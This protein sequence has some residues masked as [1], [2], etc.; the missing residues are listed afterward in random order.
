MPALQIKNEKN[1]FGNPEWHS[2]ISERGFQRLIS[3]RGEVAKTQPH[4][5][6]AADL[7]IELCG[8]LPTVEAFLYRQKFD[9]STPSRYK[10]N[11]LECG[12]TPVRAWL[13]VPGFVGKSPAKPLEAPALTPE[14][15]G[16][17]AASA[18]SRKAAALD[19]LADFLQIAR[20]KL[21]GANSILK[22]SAQWT[23]GEPDEQARIAVV[24]AFA[25][26]MTRP[27]GH[28]QEGRDGFLD[29]RGDLSALGSARLF[30]SAAAAMR[31]V[32]SRSLHAMNPVV[33]RVMARAVAIDPATP[34][35]SLSGPMAAVIAAEEARQLR[36]ALEQASVETLRARL[37]ELEAAQGASASAAAAGPDGALSS[38][39][40]AAAAKSPKRRL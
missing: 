1:L 17:V 13:A 21:G 10:A 2:L 9:M 37:S 3:K 33:V 19:E 23:L 18:L 35:G 30:E 8:A 26:F 7:M 14:G 31:T 27:T 4:L 15:L 32:A 36:L 6:E 38:P 40:P 12:P 25:L 20:P 22:R 5:L 28:W 24:D 39:P 34:A 11:N 29:A 16:W